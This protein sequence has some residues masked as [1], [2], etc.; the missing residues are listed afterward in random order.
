MTPEAF[1]AFQTAL[2]GI[3]T[4]IKDIVI[5]ILGWAV[6]VLGFVTANP[7]VLI[8]FIV[9]LASLAFYTVKSFVR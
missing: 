5:A 1:T 3:L 9:P 2:A 7:L 6:S 8:F 4:N